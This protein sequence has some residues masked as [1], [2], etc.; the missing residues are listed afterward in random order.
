MATRLHTTV[1]D[2]P[3]P[4]ALADFYQALLGLERLE[5]EEDWASVG[6]SQTDKRLGFQ[7]A[8]EFS[9]PAWPGAGELQMHLDFW[10]DDVETE[11]RRAIEL[12]AKRLDASAP[13]FWVY[14]DP[15]GHIFC[16]CW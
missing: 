14:A 3:D 1:L 12:G 13:D 6:P 2:C 7:L 5:S 8:P 15:A 4:N 11:H 16:L 10:V 9:P